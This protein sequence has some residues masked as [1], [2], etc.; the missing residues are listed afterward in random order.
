MSISAARR[1]EII[2]EYQRSENDSGSPEVQIAILTE[3][4]NKLTEH[5]RSNKHDYHSRKG[6]LAMVSNRNS[7]LRYLQRTRREDYLA[8][9][10]KLGLRK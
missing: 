9:I 8:L 5:M 1:S 2:K 10:K 4:I 3:R 6:L 7:L